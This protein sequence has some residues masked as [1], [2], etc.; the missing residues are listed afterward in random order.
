MEQRRYTEG[1]EATIIYYHTP[2]FIFSWLEKIY[3]IYIYLKIHMD[4]FKNYVRENGK[5]NGIHVHIGLKAG[6]AALY[7]KFR[8]RI[9]YVVSE[10]WSGLCPEAKPN[11]KDESFLSRW[12]WKTVMKNA[13]GFSAVSEYLAV[14]LQD[15]FSLKKVNVIPNVVDSNMFY[16]SGKIIKSPRFIHI[17]S[18]KNYPKNINDLLSAAAILVNR[19]PE[20]SLIIFGQPSES[21]ENYARSLNL[22]HAVEFKGMS[23]QEILRAYI[24]ESMAL[25]LY[26]RFE[27]FGCVIIEANACGKPV[28]VSDI[29]VFHENVKAGLTGSFVP[30]NSPQLLADAMFSVANDKYMFDPEIIHKWSVDHYSFEKV[31]KQ[32]VKFYDNHFK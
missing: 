13:A 6:I 2:D 26:S 10:H 28:I 8:H 22:G 3:S 29:P 31:G 21:T 18:I 19:I 4:Y 17:S 32:F 1:G 7:L 16:P 20:F 27:T 11:F 9:P 25:I 14:S 24:Q 23:S 12:L 5:P 15:L 30:L